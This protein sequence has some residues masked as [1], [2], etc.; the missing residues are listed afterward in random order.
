M[1]KSL[2]SIVAVA[3]VSFSLSAA[4]PAADAA[5]KDCADCKCTCACCK[6]D[7]KSVV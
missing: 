3:L 1:F 4:E 5:K 7:R 6:A 2:A